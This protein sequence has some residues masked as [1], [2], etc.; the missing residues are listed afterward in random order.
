VIRAAAVF[1][2]AEWRKEV[3]LHEPFF[4]RV[5]VVDQ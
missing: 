5:L 1:Q 2:S 4:L 3:A